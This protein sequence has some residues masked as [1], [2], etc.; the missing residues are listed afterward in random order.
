MPSSKLITAHFSLCPIS[1]AFSTRILT[2][3]KWKVEVRRER[4][5]GQ[6]N[7]TTVP[8]ETLSGEQKCENV[9]ESS[10][11]RGVSGLGGRVEEVESEEVSKIGQDILGRGPGSS[12]LK[13][14]NKRS[15]K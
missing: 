7:P 10:S 14:K 4:V 6:D 13:G 9:T 3:S 2:K 11:D 5:A 8:A 15:S 12:A 1:F